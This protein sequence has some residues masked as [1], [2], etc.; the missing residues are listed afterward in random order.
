V[1]GDG[2]VKE[3]VGPFFFKDFLENHEMERTGE[4]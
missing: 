2:R 3:V 1:F 4:N